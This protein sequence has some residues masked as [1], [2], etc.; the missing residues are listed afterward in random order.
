MKHSS[1]ACGRSLPTWKVQGDVF[2]G[3]APVHRGHESVFTQHRRDML[4]QGPAMLMNSSGFRRGCE[5]D[6][7]ASS[8]PLVSD[9][10]TFKAVSVVQRSDK[11]STTK[12]SKW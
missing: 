10:V 2:V 5:A 12:A 9:R 4:L 3:S 8:L 6:E 11:N 1:E 7:Q